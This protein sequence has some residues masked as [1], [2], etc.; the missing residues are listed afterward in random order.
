[1]RQCWLIAVFLLF[2]GCLYCQQDYFFAENLVAEDKNAEAAKVLNHL[3]DSNAYVDRPAMHM[4]T[5]NLAGTVN[6][7]LKDSARSKK[8]FRS[9][10][11]YYDTLS[12]GY[13][14]NDFIKREWYIA[15][16]ELAEWSLDDHRPDETI[17]LL[18]NTGPPGE[19]YS[20][21]GQ[22]VLVA[23][24]HYYDLLSSSFQMLNK[25]DSAFWY[26][27]KVHEDNPL[28]QFALLFRDTG[29]HLV[30][31]NAVYFTSQQNESET[32]HAHLYV[33]TWMNSHSESNT[34][35]CV[36]PEQGMAKLIGKSDG[37][38]ND[39]SRLPLSVSAISLS[40]TSKWLA[41]ECYAE[42]NTWID[43]ISFDELVQKRI[44][45]TECSI[46]PYPGNVSLH[47]WDN[48]FVIVESDADL[49]KLNKA[50]RLSMPDLFGTTDDTAEFLFDPEKKK[51]T[52]R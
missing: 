11:A 26:L 38:V 31:V 20:A 1:M 52:K 35:W 30:N 13:K 15:S 16:T 33:A 5:L 29:N 51:Y 21:T 46:D 3:I 19:Y 45:A 18:K 32:M 27:C 2:A 6:H 41:V 25:P 14:E 12:H 42:G 7:Y 44:Y 22:D 24:D 49:T 50:T 48:E 17:A 43:V 47:G 8:C 37:A 9:A 10:I 39:S 40:E 4:K 34:I 23:K 36:K 28:W